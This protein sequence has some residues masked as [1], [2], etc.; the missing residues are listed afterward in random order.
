MSRH[1]L[2]KALNEASQGRMPLV[3]GPPV[4]VQ[5]MG[6]QT[7]EQLWKSKNPE[8]QVAAV[9]AAY[10]AVEQLGTPTAKLQAFQ[11]LAELIRALH[12]LLEYTPTQRIKFCHDEPMMFLVRRAL[13]TI[14]LSPPAVLM[15]T[16]ENRRELEQA[17]PRLNFL[18]A[19]LCH[20]IIPEAGME[21][22]FRNDLEK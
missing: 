5:A 15:K 7:P 20:K 3:F 12:G 10:Q 17:T 18:V 21:V 8:T 22:L 9:E 1:L 13:N 6:I 14:P 4:Y 2:V 16:L 11:A 19:H